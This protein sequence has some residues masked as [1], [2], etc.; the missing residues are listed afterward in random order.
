MITYTGTHITQE[1]GAPNITDMAVQSMRQCRFAGAGDRVPFWPVGLHQLLVA[2]IAIEC[3]G[4]DNPLFEFYCLVHDS[5]SETA[6]GDPPVPMKTDDLRKLMN[7]I[8]QRAYVLLGVAMPN[9]ETKLL[10]KKYDWMAVH[11]E[12]WAGC[13]PRGYT[14]TQHNYEEPT[15]ATKNIIHTYIGLMD[16]IGYE[17]LFEPDGYWP[18]LYD[19]RVR[20]ALKLYRNE[21]GQ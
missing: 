18:S 16:K 7:R 19:E 6:C 5:T 2:D 10:I 15:T 20:H 14:S 3:E 9:Q 21:G 12:G 13:A 8:D 17:E 4:G 11:A 1:F